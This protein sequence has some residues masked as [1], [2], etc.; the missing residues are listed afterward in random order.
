MQITCNT[1]G[2]YHVCS[3]CHMVHRDGSASKFYSVEIT[4]ILASFY[5]L[6]LVSDEGGEENGVLREKKKPTMSLRMYLCSKMHEQGVPP[7]PHLF[8]L[9]VFVLGWVFLLLFTLYISLG[10]WIKSALCSSV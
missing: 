9:F 4:F 5:W 1:L 3:L 7:S 10:M 6:K 8:S 2:T